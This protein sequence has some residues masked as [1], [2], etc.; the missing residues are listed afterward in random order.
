MKTRR[1]SVAEGKRN[2][3]QL[4]REAEATATTVL[5]YRHDRLAGALVP[6]E[7]YERMA[8]TASYAT[9]MRLSEEL[10][11]LD[12]NATDLAREARDTLAGDP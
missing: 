8:R 4:L 12:V 9:A 2:L 5:I 7:T 3:T 6:P 11:H 1:V 10:A